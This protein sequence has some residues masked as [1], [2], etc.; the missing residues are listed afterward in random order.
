MIQAAASAKFFERTMSSQSEDRDSRWGKL[1]VRSFLASSNSCPA[2]G[3][4]PLNFDGMCI[5]AKQL[6]MRFISWRVTGTVNRTLR[7]RRRANSLASAPDMAS[8]SDSFNRVYSCVSSSLLST[9]VGR[10]RY[11]VWVLG[12][13]TV[14][15]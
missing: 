15:R 4:S 11:A 9:S 1:Q 5:R 12:L 14:K 2:M 8:R 10:C 6:A 3:K 13:D 7:D